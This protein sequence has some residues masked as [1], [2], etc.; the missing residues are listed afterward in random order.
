MEF[1]SFIN[2]LVRTLPLCMVLVATIGTGPAQAQQGGTFVV[3][4]DRGG[5]IGDRADEI[6]RLTAYGIKVEIRG[7]ICYSSCT[8]YLGAGN[9]CIS[10]ST[11]FGFHG[12]SDWG[13]PLQSAEFDRWSE[14]MARFYNP[15][16]RQI[17]MTEARYRQV[18]L[19]RLTGEQIS[20]MGY[21]VC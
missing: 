11:T 5:P 13:R 17:F 1:N 2:T 12:P 20:A 8:M 14:I 4:N 10:P 3:G 19:Y 18:N 6:A 16:L 21:A 15:P 7:N 9:V